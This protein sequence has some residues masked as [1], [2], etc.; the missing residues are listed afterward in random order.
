MKRLPL[1]PTHPEIALRTASPRARNTECT[2]CPLHEG[3]KSVCMPA[4]GQPGG[5]LIVGEAPG[6]MEDRMGRPF[7]SA[8]NQHVRQL[9]KRWWSGPVVYDNALR[10]PIVDLKKLKP[11]HIASCREYG[12]DVD[13]YTQPSRIICLGNVAV[14]SV[15]GH[16]PAGVTNARGGFAY[17]R[18]GTPVFILPNPLLAMRNRFLKADFE[19]DLRLALTATPTAPDMSLEARLVYST[20]DA[21]VAS[22]YLNTAVSVS[23]DVETSG[24]MGNP[25]FQIE[26]LG[27]MTDEGR[28]FVWTREAMRDPEAREPLRRMLANP[29]V[30]KITQNGKYDDRAVLVDLKAHVLGTLFDTRLGRKLLE[31]EASADLETIG[32]LV[33]MGGHKE[34]ADDKLAVICAELRRLADPLPA[35]TPT[36]KV[37]K[38]P[39]P[40]FAVDAETLRQI[41]EGEDAKAFAFR[42]LDPVTLYRYNARDVYVTHTA[43]ILLRERL[44]ARPQLQ[45]VWTVLTSPVNDAI[46]YLEHWGIGCDRA[47]VQN[48]AAYCQSKIDEAT[49]VLNTAAPGLNPNSVPQVSDFLYGKL[50]LKPFKFTP[51]G[52]PSTDNDVLEAYAS[53][54]AAI[55]ALVQNRSYTKLN[56]TYAL[57]ML[58]HIRADG[59]IHPSILID[60]TRT[61]RFSCADPNLQNIPRAEGTV[62]AAFARNCFIARPGWRLVELDYS[63]IEVRVAALLSGDPVMIA[64]LCAGI[65]I[66]M[67]NATLSCQA[68]FGISPAV[69]ATMSKDA[70]KPYR[71]KIKTA[72]FAKLYGKTA[73]ALAHEWGVPVSEVD[74]INAVI[75]GRYKVLNA[76]TKQQ[77]Q[78]AQKLGYV[79][80]WWDGEPAMRRYIPQIAD[81][82]EGM[83]QHAENEAVNT[84]V[85]GTAAHFTAASI[86]KLVQWIIEESFPA[87]M[88][89]T[90]HDSIMFEVPVPY[91]DE[92]A[93][94]ARKVM[95]SH[96][97]NGVPI[98]VECKTGTSWGSMTDYVFT[99]DQ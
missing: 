49:K 15:L 56:G 72:T 13:A 5:V 32:Y 34:E 57:G 2:A 44:R 79:E 71:T 16:R 63:Q 67:N 29:N 84:P 87:I 4:D 3:T 11:A 60:G 93:H 47:A 53:K 95:R 97:S 76:W 62:D 43:S 78:R 41:R 82:D 98:D 30:G 70:R 55:N 88:V 35:L 91:V 75:W 83:R 96:N 65:D 27:A 12:A 19:E 74:K 18:N 22:R 64:D 40:K 26:C 52:R 48:F 77:I 58:M 20:A 99:E 25:D 36:G 66:H 28:L 92:L 59:R 9:V 24:K 51:T 89:I 39:P 50:G 68:A 85:Q 23:Y 21:R 94:S 80:T 17:T 73:R 37:R 90:V 31:P 54:H 14:L 81:S 42:Y 45:R 7:S 69:W 61:G 38:I 86:A 6:K 46:R 33:G 10:C 1:Y 8:P